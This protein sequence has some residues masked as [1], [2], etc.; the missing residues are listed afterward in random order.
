MQTHEV[1]DYIHRRLPNWSGTVAAEKLSGGYLNHVW[2]VGV[3]PNSVIVKWAPN[4][5]ATAPDIQLDAQR[6]GFEARALRLLESNEILEDLQQT[7][8]R[9]PRVLYFN[10]QDHVL[11]LEDFGPLCALDALLPLSTAFTQHVTRVGK[12]IGTLHQKTVSH[13]DLARYFNN[14]P[15]QLSRQELQYRSVA[16]ICQAMGLDDWQHLGQQAMILSQRLLQPGRTLTMGDLWPRSI[17]IDQNTSYLI[18]WEFCHYGNPLQDVAHLAAHLWMLCQVAEHRTEHATAPTRRL[19]YFLSA[20]RQALNRTFASLWDQE[21][22]TLCAVHFGCEIL[23]RILGPF[24]HGYI[25]EGMDDSH[26]LIRQAANIAVKH[27]RAPQSSFRQTF[28]A[29]V[30]TMTVT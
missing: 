25:Y 29:L 11:V 26:P 8:V 24:K 20:Y 15:I 2:R 16:S 10:A 28:N 9:A 30:Q 7:K 13:T 12:F 22:Q 21:T 23:T 4:H 3:F 17:L 6:I 5:I 1:N 14:Q 19:D 18:D 27:L